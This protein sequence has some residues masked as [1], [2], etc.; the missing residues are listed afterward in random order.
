MAPYGL[1]GSGINVLVYDGGDA[2]AT[3]PDF[4]GRLTVRDSAGLSD[5]ATHVSGTVG[6]MAPPVV[7]TTG[8]WP[9]R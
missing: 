6:V 1:N 7:A 9:P 4:S 5:H 8:G 2:D 3:H